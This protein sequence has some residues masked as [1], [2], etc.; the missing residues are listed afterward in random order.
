MTHDSRDNWTAEKP[1]IIKQLDAMRE[2][3]DAMSGKL[4]EIE[5]EIKSEIKSYR[6]VAQILIAIGSL[7]GAVVG[8][9]AKALGK[10]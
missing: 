3:I 8:W 6:R 1:Y 2:S 9:F 4:A 7:V 5:T 10:A